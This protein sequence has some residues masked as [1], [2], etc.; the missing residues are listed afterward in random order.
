MVVILKGSQGCFPE[1]SAEKVTLRRRRDRVQGGAL[2]EEGIAG[3][4]VSGF[5]LLHSRVLRAEP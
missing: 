5:A 1:R 2:P 3:K 4:V